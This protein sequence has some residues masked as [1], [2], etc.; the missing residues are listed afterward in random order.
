MRCVRKLLRLYIHNYSATS[1]RIPASAIVITFTVSYSCTLPVSIYFSYRRTCF[2]WLAQS[3]YISRLLCLECKALLC[4]SLKRF[5]I[6]SCDPRPTHRTRADSLPHFCTPTGL[7]SH[8]SRATRILSSHFFFK[9]IY[10]FV[11]RETS[12]S[13]RRVTAEATFT[14]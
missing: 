7:T 9:Y 5:M 1:A 12:Q 6:A 4:R 2:L 10:Q 3:V 8:T 11:F 13:Q 14:K